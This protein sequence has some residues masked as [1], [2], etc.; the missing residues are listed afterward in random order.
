MKKSIILFGGPNTG[1][2]NYCRKMASKYSLDGLLYWTNS[3]NEL[4][5]YLYQPTI[6]I[7]NIK[8]IILDGIGSI[9]KLIY[10][11]SLIYNNDRFKHIK[12]IITSNSILPDVMRDKFHI[13]KDNFRIV[14]TNLNEEWI[15]VSELQAINKVPFK[16][17][18]KSRVRLKSVYKDAIQKVIVVFTRMQADEALFLEAMEIAMSDRLDKDKV[19]AFINKAYNKHAS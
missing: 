19:M 12:L 13:L 14:D 11:D 5:T 15:W 17:K 8:L 6:M 10:L 4:R 9:K 1:K 3:I 7:E 16:L 18:S 2:S